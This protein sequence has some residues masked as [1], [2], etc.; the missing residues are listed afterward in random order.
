MKNIVIVAGTRPEIIKVAPLLLCA[1]EK[2]ADRLHVELCM[3]GQHQS[4]AD[5][6]LS[7]FGLSQDYN[8]K[9]MKPNQTPNDVCAAVFERL[10]SILDKSKPD[11]VLVQGDTTSATTSAMCAFNLK[12]PVAHIEAGLRSHDLEAPFPEEMNRKVISGFARYNFCP[13]KAAKRNLERE[14]VPEKTLFVTGNTIVDAIRIIEQRHRLDDVEKIDA[15]IRR[16]FVLITA[17]R[18]ESFGT[19]ILNICNA[20]K[21]IA[22]KHPEYQIIYPVHPNPNINVPVREILGNTKNVLLLRPVA[23]LDLLTLLKNCTLVI[24]D[25]GG[26]QEESPSFNKYCIVLRDVTERMESVDLGLSELVGTN[27]DRIVEAFIKG[28][29]KDLR[30][31]SKPNP[32]GDGYAS[33]R[34]LGHLSADGVA[35]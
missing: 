15:A 23:Y 8:L 10:P 28:L 31:L 29:S 16:P 5:E 35:A 20:I 30:I 21:V 18:R 7:I 3:T 19:P 24:T 22:A 33:E 27:S 26:I 14:S 2:F 1:K 11:L 6:A 13:T 4:M 17:H 32:Y 34:I 12:I 25:S 9:I